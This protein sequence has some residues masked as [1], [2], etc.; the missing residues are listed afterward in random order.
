MCTA[1][2]VASLPGLK[3]LIMSTIS[4]GNSRNRS[5]NG[6]LQTGSHVQIRSNGTGNPSQILRPKQFPDDDSEVELV[7]MDPRS[8][9][10]Q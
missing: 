1:L 4:P 7:M 9:S 10:G 8:T 2:I 5:N 6:Y 3:A